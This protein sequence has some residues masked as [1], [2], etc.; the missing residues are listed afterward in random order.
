MET[1]QFDLRNLPLAFQE[2]PKDISSCIISILKKINSL[3]GLWSWHFDSSAQG[4]CAYIRLNS[5][6]LIH[7]LLASKFRSL[8]SLA[9]K[10]PVFSDALFS[11]V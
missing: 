2:N 1:N 5:S 11:V 3:L 7:I 8:R 4:V 10:V 6:L 9:W